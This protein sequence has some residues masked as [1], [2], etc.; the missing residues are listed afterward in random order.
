MNG[1]KLSVLVG[2]WLMIK[3]VLN[4][5]LGFSIGNFI[6]L[7]AAVVFAY[8]LYIGMP[9]ANYIIGALVAIIVIANLPYNLLHLQII[10]L[11]EAVID[12]YCVYMLFT[13]ANIK[14]HCSK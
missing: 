9:Y 1:K 12:A 4:L 3:G 11:V 7:I 13:N 2:I 6:T 14:E 8:V 10:Y 5:L